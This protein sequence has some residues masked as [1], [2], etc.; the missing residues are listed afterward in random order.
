MHG[1]T[2]EVR[3]KDQRLE[4]SFGQ[5]ASYVLGTYALSGLRPPVPPGG[6]QGKEEASQPAQG[7][8]ETATYR[9]GSRRVGGWNGH[10]AMETSRHDAATS[11]RLSWE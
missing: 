9:P 6:L 3:N 4:R 7:V 5:N 11:R 1:A 8:K 10:C 2:R